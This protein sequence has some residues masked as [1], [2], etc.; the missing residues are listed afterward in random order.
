LNVPA[1][2]LTEQ[3]GPVKN[4]EALLQELPT[5]L[6]SQQR[7]TEAGALVARYLQG[8]GDSKR[9]L[10]TLGSVLLREDRNFHTIQAIEA[11]ARQHA[12]FPETPA[13][14]HALIAAVRYLAAHSPTARSQEQT[15]QTARRLSRGEHLFEE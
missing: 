5:L 13:G 15:Y 14:I 4:P 1:A 12:L 3:G 2:L 7:V 8:G 11:A 9:L 10:A 6:N